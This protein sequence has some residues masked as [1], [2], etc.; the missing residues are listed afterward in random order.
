MDVQKIIGIVKG[1]QDGAL[2]KQEAIAVLGLFQE[3]LIA[4]RPHF[5][6]FWLRIVLDGIA[7]SLRELEDHLKELEEE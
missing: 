6:K 7:C 2:D 3:A 5:K 4:M 1:L